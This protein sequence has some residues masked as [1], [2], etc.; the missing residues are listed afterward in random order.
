MLVRLLAS[1]KRE[2]ERAYVN[3]GALGNRSAGEIARLEPTDGDGV[4]A[5]SIYGRR[6]GK[7]T[8][9]FRTRAYRS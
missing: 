5:T 9:S 8:I 4:L 1:A 6:C 2:L 7:Q 3:A